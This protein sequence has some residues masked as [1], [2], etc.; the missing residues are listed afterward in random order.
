MLDMELEQSD[1][2]TAFLFGNLDQ[3]IYMFHPEGFVEETGTFL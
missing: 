3:E 2:K 1:V